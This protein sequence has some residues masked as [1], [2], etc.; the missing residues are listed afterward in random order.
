MD[1]AI[2]AAEDEPVQNAEAA[3]Q[4]QLNQAQQT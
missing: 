4:A 2:L 1:P 3:F